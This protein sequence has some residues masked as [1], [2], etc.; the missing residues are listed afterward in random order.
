MKLTPDQSV[1]WFGLR[2]AFLGVTQVQVALMADVET[3]DFTRYK[4]HNMLPRI[5]KVES[6]AATL[7]V[8]VL[9]VLIALG[10]VDPDAPTSPPLVHGKK[11]SK[12]VWE[13]T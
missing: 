1:K 10:A 11:N 7:G 8:D 9:T 13:M 2:L 6:L 5:D 3:A 12:S 4:K